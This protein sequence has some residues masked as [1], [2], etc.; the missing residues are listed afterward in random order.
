M[1]L[2]ENFYSD[3]KTKVFMLYAGHQETF[4][5][6]KTKLRYGI[7]VIWGISVNNT[8]SLLLQ[9]SDSDVRLPSED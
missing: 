5:E 7:V 6:H 2:T 4:V 3:F 8:N 1:K 9:D